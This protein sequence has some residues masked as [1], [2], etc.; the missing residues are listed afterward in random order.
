MVNRILKIPIIVRY[1][2]SQNNEPEVPTVAL[3]DFFQVAGI[4]LSFEKGA[5]IDIYP[6]K[7]SWM[8]EEIYASASPDLG[9]PPPHPALLIIAGNHD[10]DPLYINGEMIDIKTRGIIVVF[11]NSY[12]CVSDQER[13]FE[14]FVHEIGHLLNLSHD[15]AGQQS[16][17]AMHQSRERISERNQAWEDAIKTADPRDAEVLK[18]YFADGSRS[19]LGYPLSRNSINHLSR[20]IHP[21][22]V[23]PWGSGFKDIENNR[24]DE[25]QAGVLLSLKPEFDTYHVGDPFCFE[26][27]IINKQNASPLSLPKLIGFK[28]GNLYLKVYRPDGSEYIHKTGSLVCSQGHRDLQPGEVFSRSFA[29]IDGP[30]GAMFPEP[31][32]YMFSVSMPKAGLLSDPVKIDVAPCAH[33]YLGNPKFRKFLTSA[34]PAGHS[35]Q[36]KRLKELLRDPGRLPQHTQ[37]YIAY[38]CAVIRPYSSQSDELLSISSRLGGPLR[39]REKAALTALKFHLCTDSYDKKKI[40]TEIE[41]LRDQFSDQPSN[42]L[43]H[44]ALDGFKEVIKNKRRTP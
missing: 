35:T 10:D 15:D 44:E 31:G 19:P 6:K 16:S 4:D 3:Q 22:N 21:N 36:W 17:R 11:A 27:Q 24:F 42:S 13:L 41:K 5:N 25:G 1:L 14:V 2:D 33:H 30:G 20:S 40:K 8:Y 29:F 26:I 39:T 43:I 7:G 28:F 37:A 9:P 18:S 34:L 32:I 12:D 23:L 38:Q